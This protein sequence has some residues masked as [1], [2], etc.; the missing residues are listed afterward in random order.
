MDC[1]RKTA[2]RLT[3]ADYDKYDL[4]IGMDRANIENTRRMCGGDEGGKI[5]LLMEYTGSSA[6]VADP[7]Y[8]RDF[9]AT[10]RD[11]NAGCAALLARLTR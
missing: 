3:A 8:T 10:W 7:W 1:S 4:L 5:H 6:E 11:V 2:R 9:Q